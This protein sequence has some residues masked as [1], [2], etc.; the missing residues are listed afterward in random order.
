MLT[1]IGFLEELERSHQTVVIPKDEVERLVRRFG[2][3][4]R[5]MGLWRHSTDGSLELSTSNI[6][7]AARLVGDSV[8]TAAIEELKSPTEFLG[9]FDRSGCATLQLVEQLGRLNREHFERRVQRFQDTRDPVE[10]DRLWNE[11]SLELFGA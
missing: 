5:Q 10:A 8:L 4:V 3:A 6:A 2:P 11:I 9:V 7:A 1:F